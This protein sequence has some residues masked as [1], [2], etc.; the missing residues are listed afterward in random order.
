MRPSAFP[1]TWVWGANF[2]P[3]N[4]RPRSRP[5]AWTSTATSGAS[6]KWQPD[7]ETADHPHPGT[8]PAVV[9]CEADW[10][11]WRLP[12][13]EYALSPARAERQARM[14]VA[15]PRL[16]AVAK[17]LVAWAKENPAAVP[18]ALKSAVRQ[19]EDALAAMETGSE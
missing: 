15:A 11:G 10:G 6:N 19:A 17:A 3:R 5:K 13:A 9:T 12:G 1:T 4:C 16:A 18:E 14:M 7:S 8:H 2:P